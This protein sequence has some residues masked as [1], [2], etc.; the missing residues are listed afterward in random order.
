[1]LEKHIIA[2]FSRLFRGDCEIA[3][4]VF[5]LHKN[6]YLAKRER[7][8]NDSIPNICTV[9]VGLFQAWPKRPKA[10]SASCLADLD[11]SLVDP[12][13]LSRHKFYC[14]YYDRWYFTQ[15]NVTH[16]IYRLYTSFLSIQSFELGPPTPHPLTR[17]QV[18][19]SP[20]GPR[21]RHIP[22][23]GSG[24]GDPIPT[25]GQTL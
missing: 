5:F 21:G 7:R 19:L 18:L 4:Y 8:R 11:I 15:N 13:R 9:S 1:M 16:R 10:R 24:W 22:L 12:C 20:L 14:P 25:K 3:D 6:M 23:R 2:D 17:K